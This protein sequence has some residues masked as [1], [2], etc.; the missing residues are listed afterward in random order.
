SCRNGQI[1]VFGGLANV[2]QSIGGYG[3]EAGSGT[4]QFFLLYFNISIVGL[5][6]LGQGFH[7]FF[8]NGSVVSRKLHSSSKT[9]KTFH[10]GN[11]HS[12]IYQNSGQR[13]ARGPAHVHTVPFSALDGNTQPQ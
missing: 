4:V 8:F 12:G 3:P 9:S 11:G 1:V 6:C 13:N 7:S 5:Y 2:G 10:G